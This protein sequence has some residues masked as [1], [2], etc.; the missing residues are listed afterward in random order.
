MTPKEYR[1]KDTDELL[2]IVGNIVGEKIEKLCCELTSYSRALGRREEVYEA[3]SKVIR[4]EMESLK[5]VLKAINKE[6]KQ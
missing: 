6:R 2:E 1:H 3:E 4:A 5:T